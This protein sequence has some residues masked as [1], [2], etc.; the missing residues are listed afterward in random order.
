MVLELPPR[1]T[2]AETAAQWHPRDAPSTLAT[3][4]NELS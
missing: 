2:F 4:S 1:K 3:R